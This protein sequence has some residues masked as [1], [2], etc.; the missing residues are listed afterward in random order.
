MA[1][2][3]KSGCC[4]PELGDSQ[5]ACPAWSGGPHPRG[6]WNVSTSPSGCGPKLSTRSPLSVI[7]GKQPIKQKIRASPE[8][9]PSSS[10]MEVLAWGGVLVIY[11]SLTPRGFWPP[12]GWVLSSPPT[13]SSRVWRCSDASPSP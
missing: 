4:H 7:E 8:L 1:S 11:A 6:T 10:S 9:H 2:E 13:D 3:N 12:E 5:A